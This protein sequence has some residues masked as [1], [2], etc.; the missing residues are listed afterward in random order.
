MFLGAGSLKKEHIKYLNK[1]KKIYIH[2]EKKSDDEPEQ[3]ENGAKTFLKRACLYL[4]YEKLFIISA[5]DVDKDCKDLADLHIKSLLDKDKLLGTARAVD[6]NY[7]DEVNNNDKLDEHVRLA[8]EVLNRLYIKY[9][10]EN[11]YVYEDGVYRQNLQAVEQCILDI[12]KN[13]KKAMQSEVLNYIRIKN[14]IPQNQIDINFINF[15]NGIYN[16]ETHKLEPHDPS[17]FTVCQINANYYSDGI[18][19]SLIANGDGKYIIKFLN[20]ICCGNN[21]RIDTL[22]EFTGY[23]MTYSMKLK[24]CLLLLGETADNGKSTF[25]DLL[26]ALFD[27]DNVCNVSIAEFSERFCGADLVDKQLN[28]YHEMEN[29]K[30]KNMSKF[31]II[32]A[33]NELFVEEKYK[34]RFKMRPFAHHIFAMNNLPD[35]AGEN[36]EGYFSRLHIVPFQAKFTEEQILEFDFDHLITKH[37]LDFLANWSLR[38]YLKMCDEKRQHFSNYKESNEIISSYKETENSAV[39]FMQMTQLYINC[40]DKNGYIKK[41]DLFNIYQS[42]CKSNHLESFK[43]LNFYPIVLSSGKF[44]TGTAQGGF[45]CFKYVENKI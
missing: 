11:F 4:P 43:R 6:K 21:E 17:Y 44:T 22:G 8:E 13:T 35:F 37:S 10:N 18:F 14:T 34:K 36:D 5:R 26:T 23:S 45:D 7:Y 30:L 19:K 3:K 25:L 38:K 15:K 1:F 27:S 12:D 39:Q 28:V 40:L 29:I 9:Y 42:W 16:I 20:D 2:Y 24:K 33:G 32:I 41:T 31:K